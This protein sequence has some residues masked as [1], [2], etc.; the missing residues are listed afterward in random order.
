M[1]LL[2]VKRIALRESLS[3]VSVTYQ[4]IKRD[5]KDISNSTAETKRS[6]EL[7]PRLKVK[8]R[9]SLFSLRS[10]RPPMKAN[11]CKGNGVTEPRNCFEDIN[12]SWIPYNDINPLA[13]SLS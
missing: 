1:S 2:E 5:S 3:I 10:L 12:L 9:G 6:K 7:N 4:E 11:R 8:K 13:W